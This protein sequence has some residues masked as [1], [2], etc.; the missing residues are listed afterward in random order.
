M[1]IVAN[2]TTGVVVVASQTKHGVAVCC[3]GD[4]FDLQFGVE[5][6]KVRMVP[7]DVGHSHLPAAAQ[8]MHGREFFI[9]QREIHRRYLV[10]V[11]SDT[12]KARLKSRPKVPEATP[13]V[14]SSAPVAPS[15]QSHVTLPAGEYLRL[16]AL[17]KRVEAARGS[18]P[19][20]TR[21][22]RGK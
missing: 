14:E 1:I 19:V 8:N 11:L 4:K 15:S 12:I 3:P 10:G 20:D 16:L 17:E 2:E 6:A 18:E 13:P 9:R 7:M 21:H 22:P 5:L